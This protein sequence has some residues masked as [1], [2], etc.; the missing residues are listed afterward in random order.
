MKD[1]ENVT[2]R[3]GHGEAMAPAEEAINVAAAGDL[4]IMDATAPE[5][6]GAASREAGND[7]WS[8]LLQIGT[9]IM[10]ALS[11]AGDSSAASH[12]WIERDPATGARNL[13]IPLPPAETARRLADALSVLAD[14]LRGRMP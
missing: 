13:K 8:A 14:T 12:P 3:M 11:A 6:G 2:G 9:Q 1:V 5:A 10:S 7:P 4:S